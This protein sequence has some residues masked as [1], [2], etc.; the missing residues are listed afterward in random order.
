MKVKI[1]CWNGV[2]TWLWVA[3]DENC[4]ICRMAF[5]GCC[6]DCPL[7][8]ESISRCLGWCPQPVPVL[9]GRAHAQVPIN[10]ASPTPGQHTGS[11]MSREESSRSPDPTPPA[12]DQETSSLLRCTSP[13]CLDHSCDLFGITD[14]VSADGPR[15]CR[16]GARRRLP[17]GVGPVLPLLPHA[18]HPQVAARAAGAAALPHV[19][20]G[21]EVQGVRPDLALAGGAS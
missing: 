5:N 14:Q 19:P 15:A 16:Q 18:L 12:L 3:N 4:G 9:G 20:P 8:G 21:M 2:A 10:T 13:W 6:P 11:L 1:K 7:H 17:A